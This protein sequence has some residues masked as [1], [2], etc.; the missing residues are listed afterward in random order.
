MATLR[1]DLALGAKT[2]KTCPVTS[3][4]FVRV[5]AE[6]SLELTAEGKRQLAPFWKVIDPKSS[7]AKKLSCGVDFIGQMLSLA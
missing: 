5:V 7:L 3:A 4:I 6:R 1:R 2:D